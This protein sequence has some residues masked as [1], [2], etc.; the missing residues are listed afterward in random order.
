MTESDAFPVDDPTD[1]PLH[2]DNTGVYIRRSTYKQENEHQ[3]RAINNWLD[4]YDLAVSDVTIYSDTASGYS[5]DREGLRELMDDI[6]N[7]ELDH[8]VVWELSRI[9]REGELA[10][11]FFNMC[12]ENGVHVHI[13]SGSIREIK[14]DG[15]NRFVADI[16]SAVYAEERRTLIR[17]T[18]YGVQRA[19]DNDKWVGSPPLGFTTDDEG[20]LV[21]NLGY[22]DDTD[23]FFE[24]REAIKDIHEDDAS[25]RSVAQD[26]K[27]ARTS[28]ARV[29]KD[30]EKREWYLNF[31][32]D[33]KRVDHA[34]DVVRENEVEA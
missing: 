27:A 15:T 13:T 12:E 19:K 9:A 24:I 21:P 26:L 14:P 8:V 16:L 18:K 32:A 22:N 1:M 34:L 3:R 6:E 25:F 20:Y 31:E 10:Q 4:Q 29:Y 23:N 11:K 33:D 28:I 7:G 17:R 5:S 30:E 2:P